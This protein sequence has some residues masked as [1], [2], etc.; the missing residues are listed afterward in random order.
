MTTLEIIEKYLEENGFDGLCSPGKCACKTG[1]LATCY[2]IE[3]DC[4]AGYLDKCTC[5]EHD[6]VISTN[7]GIT[8]DECMFGE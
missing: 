5:G 2:N 8:C 7:K 6:F 3:P 1:D 4:E